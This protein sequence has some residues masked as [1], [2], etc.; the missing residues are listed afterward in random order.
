M[1]AGGFTHEV[2]D[3]GGFRFG[4][5]DKE[6]A[7]LGAMQFLLDHGF[8]EKGFHG[9]EIVALLEAYARGVV[10][11]RGVFCRFDYGA[12]GFGVMLEV[13][14]GEAVADIDLVVLTQMNG[15]ASLAGETFT[16]LPCTS[17]DAMTQFDG[18][19][20]GVQFAIH[21][22]LYRFIQPVEA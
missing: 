22:D 2:S 19:Y 16:L 6:T 14:G 4:M 18:F 21:E 11:Q 12:G 10:E 13:D 3:S 8:T 5:G 7:F 17:Y 1:I 9:V 20:T 15:H